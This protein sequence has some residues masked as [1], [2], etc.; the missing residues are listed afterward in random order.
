MSKFKVG[1]EVRAKRDLL[2]CSDVRGFKKGETDVITSM[3]EFYL[4]FKGSET[5]IAEDEFTLVEKEKSVLI[6]VELVKKAMG[7]IYNGWREYRESGWVLEKD[8][9]GARETIDKLEVLLRGK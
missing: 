9:S 2:P 1:D 5:G 7:L 3:N 4:R 8:H 6:P